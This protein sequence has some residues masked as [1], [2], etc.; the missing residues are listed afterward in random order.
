MWRQSG[1]QNWAF[2]F[3]GG[4]KVVNLAKIIKNLVETAGF[5]LY[6]TKSNNN[7]VLK[8]DSLESVF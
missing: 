5:C 7:I 4:T 1:I 2:N 3:S 8:L 6:R